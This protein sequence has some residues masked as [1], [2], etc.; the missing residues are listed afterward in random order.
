MS[1]APK[2]TPKAASR[3]APGQTKKPKAD[4]A[5]AKP[6]AET[7][8]EP[9]RFNS[10]IDPNE[11]ALF[12]GT[13][14]P[15]I[16]KLRALLNTANSNLRTAYK[17]AKADGFTKAD[18]DAAIE[19]DTA[20]KEAAAKAR[21]ARKLVIA[22]YMGSDLGHQLDM[23]LEPNRVPAEDRAYEEGQSAS[24]EGKTANPGYD[25][26][27]PQHANYM[28]GYNE[29]Q[30]KRIKGGI[31][32][33]ETEETAPKTK[34]ITKAEKEAAAAKAAE[35]AEK[36]KA[37]TPAPVTSGVPMSRAAFKAQ[38]EK[39]KADAESI[40]KKKEAMN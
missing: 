32:K 18:F 21:I 31:K 8:R 17:T 30:E 40:F 20:E 37:V 34:V 28:K 4:K 39:V 14:L 33:L 15:N 11:K 1:K 5:A 12:V 7:K 13:H 23:F 6:V 35:D 38:Q 9:K 22:R 2:K 36:V 16:I 10:E 24:M 29:D 27:T 3:Q 26:S 19:I 25:P